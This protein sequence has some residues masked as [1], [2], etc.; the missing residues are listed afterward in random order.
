MTWANVV[1]LGTSFLD[2][3]YFEPVVTAGATLVAAFAGSRY[4]F[5]LTDKKNQRDERLARAAA[6]NQ[7][8]F[9]LMTQVNILANL[10]AQFVD[11]VR[12]DPIRYVS[13]QSTTEQEDVQVNLASIGFLLETL[14]RN[15]LVE[16]MLTNARFRSTIGA[17]NLRSK[18][19][20]ELIQPQLLAGGI[21]EHMEGNPAYVEKRLRIAL[22]EHQFRS[23]QRLTD[24][25]ITSIDQ[26]EL[27]IR[28]IAQQLA[29]ALTNLFPK[30]WF[31]RIEPGAFLRETSR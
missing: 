6:G 25:V 19:H 18:L 27:E 1:A 20:Y 7:V 8:L 9:G 11:P 31:L 23:I 16:L 21:V 30:R 15:V 10:R 3:K 14:H 4:A 13:M 22:G 29:D 2:S 28:A 26:A 5:H 24:G 12:H 17:F